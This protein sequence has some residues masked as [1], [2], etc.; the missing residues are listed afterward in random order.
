VL[1]S[2][3]ALVVG[4]TVQVR[5]EQTGTVAGAKTNQDGIYSIPYLLPGNY[6]L[7]AEMSGF[8]RTERRGIEVR[9]NDNLSVDLRLQLGNT[10]ESIGYPPRLR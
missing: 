4:A 2:S 6:T 3:G 5:N 8:K 9:V 10:S 7:V 1:D